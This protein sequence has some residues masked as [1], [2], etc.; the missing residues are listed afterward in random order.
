MYLLFTT[1]RILGWYTDGRNSALEEAGEKRHNITQAAP[2][3]LKLA[4]GG[5]G[6]ES[7]LSS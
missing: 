1:R 5:Y 2:D 6:D 7:W 4:G 3:E